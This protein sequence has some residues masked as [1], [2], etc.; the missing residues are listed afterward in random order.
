MNANNIPKRRSYTIGFKRH[1]IKHF[2]LTLNKSTTSTK[3]NC[4]RACLIDWIRQKDL[5]MDPNQLV[6]NRKLR[7]HENK[8]HAMFPSIE[9]DVYD[10]F[11]DQRRQKFSI[12]AQSVKAKM[13]ELVAVSKTAE[14]DEIVT[15][16]QASRGLKFFLDLFGH[17]R[18]LFRG[19][20]FFFVFNYLSP[21]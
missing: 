6:G 5:L 20:K 1:A 17:P 4:S 19:P 2:E 8:K 15:N 3:L 10:W 16:F 9:K 14:N 11:S 13:L 12:D 18:L 7:I 21:L